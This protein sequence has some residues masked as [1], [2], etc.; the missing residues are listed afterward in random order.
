[1][2][3]WQWRQRNKANDAILIM[4]K[5]PAHQRWQQCHCDKDNNTSLRTAMT[6]LQWG[7]QCYC[8]NGIDTWTAKMPVHWWW[9][10]HCNEGNDARS[11]TVKTSAHRWWQW[12][13]C[14]EGN[15]PSLMTMIAQLWQRSH[16]KKGNNCHHNN[17]E[18]TCA[19]MATLQSW[20][21]QQCHC[22]DSKDACT[23]MMIMMPLQRGQQ[24]QLE[25]GMNAIATRATMPLLIKGNN[26]IVTRAAMLAWQWQGHRCI[27][28]G[29]NGIT[30]RATIA[31][32]TM[33][34][35]PAHHQQQCHTLAE[36]PLQ[37][38]QQLPSWWWQRCLCIIGNNTIATRATIAINWFSSCVDSVLY[39]TLL[40]IIFKCS[41]SLHNILSNFVL[42][43]EPDTNVQ[44]KLIFPPII[45]GFK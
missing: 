11:T 20:Q 24:C 27:I 5:M 12:P 42:I 45:D 44:K 14:N 40:K 28:N 6:P 17:G 36:M 34:K 43:I 31:I 7:Q 23:S 21:G 41:T 26:A 37:Q 33:A 10:H 8:D 9:Q 29:N 30:I 16:C 25:D 18:D 22:N 2:Q 38:G 15:D 35:M 32:T 13:N 39:A 3:F 1:M 4:V 19:S